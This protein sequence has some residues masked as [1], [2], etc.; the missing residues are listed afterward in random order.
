MNC[1]NNLTPKSLIPKSQTSN[2]RH[3]VVSAIFWDTKGG[4]L[5]DLNTEGIHTLRFLD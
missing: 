3:E 5:V 1:G 4:L 2:G